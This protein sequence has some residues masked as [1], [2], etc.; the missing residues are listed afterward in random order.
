MTF[1]DSVSVKVSYV[2]EVSNTTDHS[3]TVVST[4][5]V[6][7]ATLTDTHP[8]VDVPSAALGDVSYPSESMIFTDTPLVTVHYFPTEI[9]DTHVPSDSARATAEHQIIIESFSFTE[10]VSVRIHF[11]PPSVVDLM[12]FTDITGTN[13]G[14]QLVVADS[15]T[16]TET[17]NTRIQFLVPLVRD[18]MTNLDSPRW[19]FHFKPLLNENFTMVDIPLSARTNRAILLVETNPFQDVPFSRSLGTQRLSASAVEQPIPFAD[20]PLLILG[21]PPEVGDH[22][23][24]YYNG[25]ATQG[26]VVAAYVGQ[27][28][29]GVNIQSSSMWNNLGA[30]I[31]LPRSQL[32]VMRK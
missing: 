2:S 15:F 6:F 29:Y 13:N 9:I 3:D 24:F 7:G 21:S 8:F 17:I 12:N 30:T 16:F 31:I 14:L 20:S 27:Q 32:W 11:A 22:V 25:K 4:T 19:Q 1:T 18:S 28:T 23:L 5:V 26:I 10:F